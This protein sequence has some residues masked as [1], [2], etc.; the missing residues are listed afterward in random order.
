MRGERGGL[1]ATSGGKIEIVD[2]K[3]D[4]VVLVCCVVLGRACWGLRWVWV[5]VEMCQEMARYGIQAC[6]P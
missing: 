5:S 3:G 1:G 6:L 4:Q 2:L